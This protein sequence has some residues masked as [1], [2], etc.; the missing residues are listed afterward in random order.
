MSC[1]GFETLESVEVW[2][3]V[4]PTDLRAFSAINRDE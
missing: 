4:M 1:F 2:D 3:T